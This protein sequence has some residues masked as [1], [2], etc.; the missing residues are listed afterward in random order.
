MGRKTGGWVDVLNAARRQERRNRSC[1]GPDM[2]LPKS[3]SSGK[4]SMRPAC[5]PKKMS[6]CLDL[7]LSLYVRHPSNVKCFIF[8]SCLREGINRNLFVIL[9]RE[10]P[11]SECRRNHTHI[12]YAYEKS[13][14]IGKT[15][16]QSNISEFEH[17][18]IAS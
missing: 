18:R 5:L 16:H 12:H 8:R 3:P 9:H 6:H 7:N 10:N 4:P 14:M 11:I 2:E 13:H 17:F 1:R 15:V